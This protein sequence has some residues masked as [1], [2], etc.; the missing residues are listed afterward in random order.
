[1]IFKKKIN[2]LF[3]FPFL[4]STSVFSQTENQSKKFDSIYYHIAVNISSANPV[5]AIHLA[6][7]LSLYS[8]NK[9]QKIKSLMLVA[10]ILA[11]Q[12][13]RGEAIVK[14]LEVL[15][16]AKEAKEY[17][18]LA[19]NYGFL[20]TQYRMIGF[21]D[22]GKS[23][24]NEGIKVSRL[25]SDKKQ[26]VNYI[27]MCNQELAEFALE[28]KDYKK[29]IEYLQLAM[30]TFEKEENA[31]TKCFVMANAEEML[32]RSY[33]FLGD[34]DQAI[35][36]FSKANFFI[37]DAGAGNT[38]WASLIYQSLGNAFLESKNLDSA[39]VYL[40]R[41]LSISKDSNHG[42]LKQ[43]V[44]RSVSE[45]YYQIKEI[46]SFTIYNSKYNTQLAKNTAEKR[47][48]INSAYNSL[49]ERS[50]KKSSNNKIYVI[51]LMVL[52]SAF[53]FYFIRRKRSITKE[54]DSVEVSNKSS[55]FTI[56]QK[57]EDYLE[58]KL[59]EFEESDL[60]LDK[61]MSLPKLLGL[62][63]INSKYFRRFLKNNKNTDYN[64]YIIRLRI[65]Y[66]KEKLITDKEYLNYK[67]SYLAEECGFSSH[68]KFSASFKSVLGV[69][70]SEFIHNLKDDTISS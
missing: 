66:I 2:L 47:L 28:E 7:S 14:A 9:Y 49:N 54:K 61:N 26:V 24:L 4:L 57:T 70:P 25:F 41:S 32:G 59:K 20:A 16:I 52:L 6:D 50:D 51:I 68:S 27:A 36:H 53:G 33:L 12:E 69:S 67:I 30:L 11:K 31:Q 34:V 38:I 40:K 44:F 46:D 55:D 62:L 65:Y 60:F 1:M 37:N 8:V 15:E 21:L 5:K 56:S 48:M 64:N 58:T 29:T 19:R 22:K 42:S 39:G 10:D 18:L 35:S 3:F 17:V 63:N 43:R 45:Y 23:F 13:K